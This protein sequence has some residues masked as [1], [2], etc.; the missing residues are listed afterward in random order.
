[1]DIGILYRW[2]K[3]ILVNVPYMK[4]VDSKLE[5]NIKLPVFFLLNERG[6]QSRILTGLYS[7]NIHTE[8]LKILTDVNCQSYLK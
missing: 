8:V 5:T 7:K 3:K 2:I 1:M 6:A 4:H